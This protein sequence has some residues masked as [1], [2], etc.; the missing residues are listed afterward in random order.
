M[1]EISKN[2]GGRPTKYEGGTTKL[3]VTIPTAGR[4]ELTAFIED[5]RNKH[6]QTKPTTQAKQ[7]KPANSL[8]LTKPDP[9]Q[10]FKRSIF[11]TY[12]AKP[13]PTAATKPQGPKAARGLSGPD[14]KINQGPQPCGCTQI[15]LTD[16]GAPIMS[17]CA[18]CRKAGRTR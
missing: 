18:P 10:R 9:P 11:G 3:T 1:K 14:S 13:E 5:L 6:G 15:G 7:N 12:E 4:A 8:I 2:K 17:L 16:G